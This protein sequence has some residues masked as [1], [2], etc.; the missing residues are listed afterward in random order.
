[1]ELQIFAY[2]CSIIN[3]AQAPAENV[4]GARLGYC[5]IKDPAPPTTTAPPFVPM[6]PGLCVKPWLYDGYTRH[7]IGNY[8]TIIGTSCQ[9]QEC[10]IVG[11]SGTILDM[12]YSTL[13]VLSIMPYPSV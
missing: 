9:T 2:F 12:I 6:P 13:N 4:H 8:G 1:M 5:Y 10:F 11:V 7:E 3:F